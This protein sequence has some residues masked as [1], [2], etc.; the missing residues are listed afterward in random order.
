MKR[1]CAFACSLFVGGCNSTPLGYLDGRGPAARQIASL[2]WGLIAI[3]VFV[4]AIVAALLGYAIWRPRGGDGEH[5]THD[6]LHGAGNAAAIRWIGIGTTISVVLLAAAAIWTLTT[7]RGIFAAPRASALSIDIVGHQWWWEA[8][9]HGETA[10]RNFSSANDIVI[11]AG[12]PVEISLRSSDVIHSFWIPK[13]AGKTDVIPGV[14]NHMRIEADRPGVY[15]GACTEFCGAEHA[16]MAM[17]VIALAPDDFRSWRERQLQG[18]DASAT[19]PGR[20]VFVRHCA[21]CHTI[22]GLRAGGVLGPDLSHFGSRTQIGAGALKNDHTNLELW[23]A[24]T[25]SIKP[26]AKMPEIELGA[27]DMKNVAAFLEG[28]K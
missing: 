27:D 2:G 7:V 3:S 6:A 25:Q 14:T 24:H 4:V 17:S 19:D 12:V 16:H 20:T 8:G 5:L 1:T 13:L 10:D 9:Y 23:I 15:R 26:G 22:R 18:A 11:P 28:L 21:A